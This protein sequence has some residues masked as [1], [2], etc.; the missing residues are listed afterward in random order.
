MTQGFALGW[1]L[2]ALQAA[3]SHLQIRVAPRTTC[4]FRRDGVIVYTDGAIA[5]CGAQRS[6]LV[7]V[8]ER[9]HPTEAYFLMQ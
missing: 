2:S 6:C 5:I 4:G 1:H 7:W 3:R 9:A 8:S